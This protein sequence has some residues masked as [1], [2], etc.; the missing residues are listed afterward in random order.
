MLDALGQRL[1]HEV[2]EEDDVIT[3]EQARDYIMHHLLQIAE[4][5]GLEAITITCRSVENR[6]FFV[7][8]GSPWA[9]R[10]F[11]NEVRA[12]TPDYLTVVV[13]T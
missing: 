2:R 10:L 1:V 5:A 7:V 11:S 12:F 13:T 3:Q 9:V 4:K 6:L 8:E